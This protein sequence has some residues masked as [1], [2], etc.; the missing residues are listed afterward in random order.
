MSRPRWKN[1]LY[2]ILPTL[3]LFGLAELFVRVAVVIEPSFETLP[4]PP[5][6]AGLFQ[7][8]DEL[9]WSMKP[10]LDLPFLGVPVLTNS[11]GLRSPEVLPKAAGEYRILS[12]GESSTFGSAVPGGATYTARSAD[13]LT[14]AERAVGGTRSFTA[15]NAGVPAYSSFQSLRYLE[16]R[17]L[18]LEP[19]LLLFYHELNDYLPSS[20]RDSSNTEVGALKTDWQLWKERHEGGLLQLARKSALVRVLS[21]QMARRQIASFDRE[22]FGNPLLEIGLPDIGLPPRLRRVEGAGTD[23]AAPNEAALGQRVSEEERRKI[24]ERLLAI[25]RRQRI[26]LLVIHPSYRDSRP[27]ECLLTSFVARTGVASLE[28]Y[29]LLHVEGQPSGALYRDSWHPNAVGHARLANALAAEVR[30]RFLD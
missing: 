26:D 18:D 10:N 4:L 30:R 12:L 20:L 16:S 25:A 15:I 17:G 5:E 21:L 8:D 23:A 3:A 22:N 19:D 7:P 11:L 28:A 2:G 13:A 29:P 6:S 9:F 27:H 24:L 14:A 1:W